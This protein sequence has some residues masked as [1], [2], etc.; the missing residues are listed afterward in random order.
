MS[1]S[2]D[3]RKPGETAPE[4]A[5]ADTDLD[6]ETRRLEQW[7]RPAARPRNAGQSHVQQTLARGRVHAVTVEV[8]R[9][10]RKPQRPG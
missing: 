6:A 5:S 8:K 1:S 7:A 2:P 4:P 10:P 9:A 3:G